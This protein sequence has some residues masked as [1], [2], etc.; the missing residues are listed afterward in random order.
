PVQIGGGRV[1]EGRRCGRRIPRRLHRSDGRRGRDRFDVSFG[2][3][4]GAQATAQA[5]LRLLRGPLG[6]GRLARGAASAAFAG[7]GAHQ[8][9][10]LGQHVVVATHALLEAAFQR[11]CVFGRLAR[12]G[13]QG[14]E[15][16]LDGGPNR[17]HAT[18]RLL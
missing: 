13:A 16:V 14:G 3:G 8:A 15:T 2:R 1:P 12:G 10:G 17:F 9:H 5:V 4:L 11:L 18:L 7:Y 6:H